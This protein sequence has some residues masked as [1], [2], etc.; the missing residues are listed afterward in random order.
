MSL[1][2][3][4]IDTKL[5]E[6]PPYRYIRLYTSVFKTSDHP[7]SIRKQVLIT[8]MP[9]MHAPASPPVVSPGR[10]YHPQGSEV[11]LFLHASQN[12]LPVLIKGPTGCGKTRFVEHM[13]E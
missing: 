6:L 1:S 13:A 12:R 2:V 3:C 4:I 7:A 10:Y 8:A 11:D 9:V 5:P